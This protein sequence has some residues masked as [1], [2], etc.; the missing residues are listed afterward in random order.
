MT[1]QGVNEGLKKAH[2]IQKRQ[3]CL[4]FF[5]Y[6]WEEDFEGTGKVSL[7]VHE[8]AC[9]VKLATVI[10][11]RKDGHKLPLRK[12]LIS[13]LYDLCGNVLY[14]LFCNFIF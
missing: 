6:F 9:I 7:D 5:G 8:R 2:K 11:C 1:F 4:L 14:R 3:K 10:G 13:I 12:E